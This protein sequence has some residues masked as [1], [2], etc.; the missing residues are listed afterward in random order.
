MG[1]AG[2]CPD[3]PCAPM[4]DGGKRRK[5]TASGAKRNVVSFMRD[6]LLQPSRSIP[7]VKPR[8]ESENLAR[9]APGGGF[10][11]AFDFDDR[12]RAEGAGGMPKDD[13]FTMLPNQIASKRVS[14]SCSA[15]EH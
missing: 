8:I 1:G 9:H 10:G 7:F 12:D 11:P 14:G 3:P 2:G 4:T 5:R 13:R 15:R 6:I